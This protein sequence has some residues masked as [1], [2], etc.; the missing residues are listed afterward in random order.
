MIKAIIFDLGEVL[1]HGLLGTEEYISEKYGLKVVNDHWHIKEIEK[2]FHGEI[3]EDEYWQ[4]IL[5]KYKWPITLEQLKE[6]IR[7]NFK[8]IEGTRE[9]IQ[10]LKKNGYKL[11]L[12]S[13][14]AKEWIKYC[15]EQYGYHQLF[16]SV[17]YSFEV[18]VSKPDR[19]AYELILEKLQLKPEEC[20][21]IDDK[22][23]NITAAQQLGIQGIQFFNAVQ[24][25]KDL[26][27]L[28][29]KLD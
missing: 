8:E 21:F 27:D 1:L 19:K 29:I 4:A 13:V 3:T 15:E 9:V 24:L 10:E 5:D 11:G 25:K 2:F 22:L 17:L 26:Q 23:G 16:D 28:K 20:V 14:H 6:A 7:Q 12:L 18:A